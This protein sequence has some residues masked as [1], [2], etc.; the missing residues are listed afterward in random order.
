[1]PKGGS[2]FMKSASRQAGLAGKGGGGDTK[3]RFANPGQFDKEIQ[4]LFKSIYRSDVLYKRDSRGKVIDFRGSDEAIDKAS[5]R[6]YALASKMA[7][8]IQ[9]FQPEAQ[10]V[11]SKMLQEYGKPI[12]VRSKDWREFLRTK[13]AEDSVLLNPRG[14]RGVSNAADTAARESN[15]DSS[16]IVNILNSRNEALN[17]QRRL[18]WP[19]ASKTG[20]LEGYIRQMYDLL[21]QRYSNVEREAWRRRRNK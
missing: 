11:Y 21:W 8:D 5:G 3:W 12:Y 9:E 14:K 15:E 2:G 4:D 13:K 10:T 6:I 18:I 1:M 16:T 17:A 20:N 7:Q 19:S